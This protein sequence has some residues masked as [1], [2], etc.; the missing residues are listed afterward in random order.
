MLAFPHKGPAFEKIQLRMAQGGADHVICQRRCVIDFSRLQQQALLG[1]CDP[2]MDVRGDSGRAERKGIVPL[3]ATRQGGRMVQ[4]F[5]VFRAFGKYAGLLRIQT[6]RA[7]LSGSNPAGG[8]CH[9]V[10]SFNTRES[11]LVI[12]CGTI[13]CASFCGVGSSTTVNGIGVAFPF[14][15]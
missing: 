6:T 14:C 15:K 2:E 12:F 8:S 4:E 1:R 9:C 7:I 10:P 11:P 5:G 3:L 13:A